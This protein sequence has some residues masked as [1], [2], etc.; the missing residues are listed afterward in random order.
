M[1]SSKIR[2][3]WGWRGMSLQ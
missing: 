1:I 3:Y 2:I